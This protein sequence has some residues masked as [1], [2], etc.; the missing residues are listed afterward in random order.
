MCVVQ[1]VSRHHEVELAGVGQLPG[2]THDVLDPKP[3]L[4]FLRRE[5][6]LNRWLGKLALRV[7]VAPEPEPSPSA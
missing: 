2:I 7:R 6:T 4:S 1:H 3:P 5:N